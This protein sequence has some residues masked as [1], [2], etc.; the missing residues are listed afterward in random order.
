MTSDR[1]YTRYDIVS[2]GFE[3]RCRA[4]DGT[5]YLWHADNGLRTHPDG[6]AT[7]LTDAAA[8]PDGPWALT[9]L[10]ERELHEGE[11]WL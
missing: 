6:R 1:A 8:L 11:L 4:V 10:G 7:M 9:E 2:L 3:A 5:R